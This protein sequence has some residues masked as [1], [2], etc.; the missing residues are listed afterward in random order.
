MR[1]GYRIKFDAVTIDFYNRFQRW[2]F[3]QGFSR[4]YFGN[5]MKVIKQ[6]YKEARDADGLHNGTGTDHRVS[7][8]RT[9]RPTRCI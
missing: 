3:N 5:V 6:V 2:F 7:P 4:N 9:T 8:A 1:P